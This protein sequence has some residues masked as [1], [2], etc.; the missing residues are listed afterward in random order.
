M[1]NGD[2]NG[3]AMRL[4]SI[5]DG[6]CFRWGSQKQASKG[7]GIPKSFIRRALRDDDAINGWEFILDDGRECD[8]WDGSLYEED[9]K[10][11]ANYG[12]IYS[13]TIS[14]D[15]DW[16]P[17][18]AACSEE[19][20][21]FGFYDGELPT[22]CPGCGQHVTSQDYRRGK[23]VN[24]ADLTHI[25]RCL[26]GEAWVRFVNGVI[27]TPRHDSKNFDRSRSAC[28]DILRRN[29]LCRDSYRRRDK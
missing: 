25:A 20:Y 12:I 21:S 23:Q 11:Q 22:M 29:S 19:D 7:T 9:F 4:I 27:I 17:F 8:E 10:V 18:L 3:K 13:N 14:S 26:R 16:R 6:R 28:I 2:N 5:K 24:K 15:I 1:N